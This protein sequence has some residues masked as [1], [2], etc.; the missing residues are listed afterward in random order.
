MWKDIMKVS[1]RRQLFGVSSL[2]RQALQMSHY[3]HD[4]GEKVR[5]FCKRFHNAFHNFRI[6]CKLTRLL[7]LMF[8]SENFF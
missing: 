1:I 5:K 6:A 3:S 2:E 8:F 7:S 4:L